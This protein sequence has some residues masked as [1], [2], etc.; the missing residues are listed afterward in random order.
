MPNQDVSHL[1]TG[2][3][4]TTEPQP[5]RRNYQ[6]ADAEYSFWAN[7]ASAWPC[8]NIAGSGDIDRAG[9]SPQVSFPLGLSKLTRRDVRARFSSLDTNRKLASTSPSSVPTAAQELVEYL[10]EL[11]LISRYCDSRAHALRSG[12]YSIKGAGRVENPSRR[13]ILLD[14]QHVFCCCLRGGRKV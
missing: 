8:N 4:I 10:N 14:S 13:E 3:N 12:I 6:S 5:E 9:Y 7:V 2:L 1:Q 11:D